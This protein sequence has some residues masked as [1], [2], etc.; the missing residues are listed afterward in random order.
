M[1][2]LALTRAHML[3]IE[4]EALA[5]LPRESCGVL[6]GAQTE[7]GWRVTGVETSRNLAPVDRC[8]RFEIDPAV[9][10][11]LQKA[12]RAGAPRMIGVFH[13]HPGGAAAPSETDLAQA[14]QT[15]MIWLI[16]GVTAGVAESRAF[17]RVAAGF[18]PVPLQIP[19]ADI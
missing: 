11:R 14:W 4:A 10:L 13:S 15:G 9:L 16:T 17:L 19:G 1:S 8:D 6:T 7:Q 5:A 2:V 18:T 12:A 3:R